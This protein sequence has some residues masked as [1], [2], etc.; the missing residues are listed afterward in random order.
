VQLLQ[1]LVHGQR[2]QVLGDEVQHEP[3]ADLLH[4]GQGRRLQD[5][6]DVRPL[7]RLAALK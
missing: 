5:G 2:V 4:E 1:D 3:V 7:G 6:F